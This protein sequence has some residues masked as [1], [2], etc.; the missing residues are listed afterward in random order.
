MIKKPENVRILGEC[1][2]W[3]PVDCATGYDV[4]KDGVQVATVFDNKYMIS[5]PADYSVS[6]FC[7]DAQQNKASSERGFV[8]DIEPE[9]VDRNEYL[10][11]IVADQYNV[12]F[13]D[14]FDKG[15]IDEN[16]WQT[17]QPWGPNEIVN[18]EAQYYIDTQNRQNPNS[19]NPFT[20]TDNDTLL[21]EAATAV[22]NQNINQGQSFTSGV[23]TT[24]DTFRFKYGYTEARFK[25]PQD[26][27]GYWAAVWL[28][29]ASFSRAEIDI[30]ELVGN[31]PYGSLGS[32]W[33]AFHLGQPSVSLDPNRYSG[34]VME[35]T[36]HQQGPV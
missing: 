12:I 18:N 27:S 32:L 2:S 28:Y 14:N 17:K 5:Q 29:A 22:P 16:K 20:F 23:I 30:A 9:P 34:G 10:P 21:I 4:F 33:Q 25:V 11:S 15:Y 8:F 13:E 1:L 26:V 31:E 24:F 35:F 6:A 3:Q 19:T 7:Q 36:R